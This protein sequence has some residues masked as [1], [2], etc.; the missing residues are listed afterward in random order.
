V[1]SDRDAG[2]SEF[3]ASR[4]VHLRRVAYLISGDW[5]QADDLLQTALA[6]AYVAWPRIERDGREEAYVR[7]IMVRANIDEHRRPW[8]RHERAGLDGH[9]AA[10]PRGLAHE[11]RAALLD[12]LAELAPMVRRAVVLRHWVGLSV[13]ETAAELGIAEGTVKGYCSRGLERLQATLSVQ[14]S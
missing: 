12:A 11:D 8:R 9:D 7:Q 14:R 1:V 5:H 2:Y 13:A 10:A 3:V 6:K 4:H